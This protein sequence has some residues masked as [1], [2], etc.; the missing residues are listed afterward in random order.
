MIVHNKDAG[1]IFLFHLSSYE[2]EVEY[3]Q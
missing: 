2:A 3:L 1:P